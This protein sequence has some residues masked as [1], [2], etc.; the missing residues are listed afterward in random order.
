MSFDVLVNRRTLEEYLRRLGPLSLAQES[1]CGPPSRHGDV[2]PLSCEVWR[3]TNGRATP[4]GMD[5]LE[6]A[7]R[8][9]RLTARV[10][11]AT[12]GGRLASLAAAS[13]QRVVERLA[14]GP[15]NELFFAV[16]G[17]CVRGDPRRHMAVLGMFTDSRIARSIDGWLGYGYD[18]RPGRFVFEN[19]GVLAVSGAEQVLFAGRFRTPPGGTTDMNAVDGRRLDDRW[20]QPLLG[21]LHDGHFRRSWLRREWTSAEACRVV[22]GDIRISFPRPLFET[23][24]ENGAFHGVNA[25]IFTN[26]PALI[27][28]PERIG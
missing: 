8:W 25:V 5:Q 17:V 18:K 22:H 20:T 1:D 2:H 6:L 26:V 21:G 24:G 12:W 13:G 16:P 7:A 27:S 14:L 28:R 19:D 9:A 15:Y 23:T 3:V 11:H 10:V 4:N